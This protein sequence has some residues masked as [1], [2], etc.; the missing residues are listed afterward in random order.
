MKLFSTIYAKCMN[1]AAHKRA[2]AILSALS[3]AESSFF[4]IPPDVM[5]APMCMRLPN[6]ALWFAFLTTIFSVL[7]GLAGYAIGYF[8]FDVIS[9]WLETT[10]YWDSYIHARDWFEQW[11]VWVVFIAGFSP[12]PYKLFTITAGVMVQPLLPFLLASFVGRGARFFLVAGIIRF[13]GPRIEPMLLKY[14]EWLGWIF[15]AL[16]AI[17]IIWASAH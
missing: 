15:V 3:F 8:A 12:I 7:G 11:G 6:R 4:P 13:A 2:P 14:I 9:Q 10:K 16:L 5:L 1:A 17:A